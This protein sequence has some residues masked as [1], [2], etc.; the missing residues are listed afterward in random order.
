MIKGI[1]W[2]TLVDVSL[3][4]WACNVSAWRVN[5][6]QNDGRWSSAPLK[7]RSV[8]LRAFAFIFHILHLSLLVSLSVQSVQAQFFLSFMRKMHRKGQ[9][10]WTKSL[11][12]V[13][14]L[15][16]F[17]QPTYT[18]LYLWLNR[19]IL[20]CSCAIKRKNCCDSSLFNTLQ[21]YQRRCK[22]WLCR[23]IRGIKTGVISHMCSPARFILLCKNHSA[24]PRHPQLLPFH[25]LL[26][27]MFWSTVHGHPLCFHWQHE[28]DSA[29][30]IGGLGE[31]AGV[32]L[33]FVTEQQPPSTPSSVC[34][35]MFI[36]STKSRGWKLEKKNNHFKNF[37]TSQHWLWGGKGLI[38]F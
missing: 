6:L 17:Y 15:F 36:I 27:N 2:C 32:F 24:Q 34:H 25:F 14:K 9:N 26:L 19:V 35:R 3:S 1:V 8:L 28:G 12:D 31:E 18:F 23:E 4:T 29:A 38:E 21:R 22:Q 11:R 37:I 13:V 30:W 16:F 10:K 5:Q 33:F 7:G 20:V